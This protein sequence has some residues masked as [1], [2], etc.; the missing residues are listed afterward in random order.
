[1]GILDDLRALPGVS[2][3][4]LEGTRLS[5]QV[6]DE[7]RIPPVVRALVERGGQVVRVQPREHTLEEVYFELQGEPER[8]PALVRAGGEV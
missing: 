1:M 4:R 6:E 2:G 8:A 7:A 3:A 5:A